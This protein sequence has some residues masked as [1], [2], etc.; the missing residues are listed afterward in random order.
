M[1]RVF[2]AKPAAVLPDRPKPG[3]QVRVVCPNSICRN[4]YLVEDKII[5]KKVRCPKCGRDFIASRWIDP[6]AAREKMITVKCPNPYCGQEYKIPE[7]SLGKKAVCPKCREQFV[8]GRITPPREKAAA[9][10]EKEVPGDLRP[11]SKQRRARTTSTGRSPSLSRPCIDWKGKNQNPR[12][13]LKE[14]KPS[15]F[16]TAAF[17][18]DPP[19]RFS[20]ASNYA[21]AG[22]PD[23]PQER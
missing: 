20:G 10:P 3:K 16:F 12:S 6:P 9:P 18:F 5:G 4:R 7:K 15:A 14:I 21:P 1:R 8:A 23:R 22:R 19:G 13:S 17:W 2:T 11:G